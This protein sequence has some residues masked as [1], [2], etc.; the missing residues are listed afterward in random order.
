MQPSS[1]RARFR[2]DLRRELPPI[3]TYEPLGHRTRSGASSL[4]DMALLHRST[5]KDV[6]ARTAGKQ[7]ADSIDR[8]GALITRYMTA[9]V[10]TQMGFAINRF[11]RKKQSAQSFASAQ[12]FVERSLRRWCATGRYTVLSGEHEGS[13]RPAVTREPSEDC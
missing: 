6:F 13:V 3:T 1:F 7:K 9:A 11:K 5:P 12:V 8:T 4:H 10:K 2:S